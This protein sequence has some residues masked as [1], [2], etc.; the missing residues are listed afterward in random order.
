MLFSICCLHKSCLH[1]Q[2][3]WATFRRRLIRCFD[4]VK[5]PK[6]KGQD[7]TLHLKLEHFSVSP[8][9]FPGKLLW[10]ETI[11]PCVH[12]KNQRFNTSHDARQKWKPS[13]VLAGSLLTSCQSLFFTQSWTHT[14]L[15]GS[16]LTSFQSYCF[17]ELSNNYYKQNHI[18]N[19]LLHRL[20]LDHHPRKD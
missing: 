13:K 5:K 3:F 7:N 9:L 2:V 19:Y 12:T 10:D 8:I 14:V 15:A 1:F 4:Q 17:S 16:L 18:L 20:R 6:N 11:N